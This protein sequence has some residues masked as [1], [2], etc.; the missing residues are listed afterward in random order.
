[1]SES[2]QLNHL[3][4]SQDVWLV[5]QMCFI[6]SFYMKDPGVFLMT[7]MAIQS[8]PT[9]LACVAY[10]QATKTNTLVL[11]EVDLVPVCLGFKL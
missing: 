6:L 4:G 2:L 3:E 7:C 11:N 5:L 10:L 1:M 8:I 9:V